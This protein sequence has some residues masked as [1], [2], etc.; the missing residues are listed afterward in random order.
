MHIELDKNLILTKP[1]TFDKLEHSRRQDFW[2][3]EGGQTRKSHAMTSSDTFKKNF[4]ETRY[5]RMEDKKLVLGLSR[6]RHFPIREGLNVNFL[7]L[8]MFKMRHVMSKLSLT[9]TH[10]RRGSGGEGAIFWKIVIL[11]VIAFVFTKVAFARRHCAT[12]EKGRWHGCR[13]Y[14]ITVLQQLCFYNFTV[15]LFIN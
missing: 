5:C 3:G 13:Y 2:L 8:K 7:Y 9:H 11:T 12:A 1:N 15:V 4:F 14:F 6:N 10:H